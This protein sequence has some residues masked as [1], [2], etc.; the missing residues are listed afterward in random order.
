MN[1]YN[2]VVKYFGE[3][4]KKRWAAALAARRVTGE[5]TKALA[6][7]LN[8][9][10]DTIER[11]RDAGFC[12]VMLRSRFPVE[13]LRVRPLLTVA[14]FGGVGKRWRR[15]EF[16][17][18]DAINYLSTSADNGAIL[19]QMN[20]A[21]DDEHGEIPEFLFEKDAKRAYNA[22][23]KTINS[24]DVPEG[25]REAAIAFREQYEIWKGE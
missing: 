19:A 18:I 12:Y 23:G 3:G 15:Y 24:I 17:P 5:E 14:H 11:L 16:D 13:V 22:L 20:Q 9:S 8:V 2:R 6:S 7:Y 4:E 1:N 10:S 25:L 21:I